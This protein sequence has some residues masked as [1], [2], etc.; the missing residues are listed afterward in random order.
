M[1]FERLRTFRLVLQLES[2][3]RAAEELFLSQPAVSLQVRQLERELGV[4]LIDR[5]NGRIKP[6]AAGNVV[7]EFAEQAMVTSAP[8][9]SSGSR[10]LSPGSSSSPSPVRRPRRRASSLS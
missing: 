7:L 5:G 6:T 2:F 9:S 4:R 10:A 3:S 8:V 1:N